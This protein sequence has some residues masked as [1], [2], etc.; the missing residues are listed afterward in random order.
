M[1]ELQNIYYILILF[2]FQQ[3]IY[4]QKEVVGKVEIY[5]SVENEWKILE[6][7][8]DGTIENLTNKEHQIKVQDEYNTTDFKTDSSGLFK[9]RTT[10]NDSIR[11]TVNDHSPI[12]NGEFHFDLNEI[13]D[14]LKLRI[15]D[16]KLAVYRDSILEPNFFS[17]FNEQQ[18]ETNFNN[19]K[20]ELLG[21]AVCWPS[22]ESAKRR[23][24]IEAEYGVKYRYYF[25]PTREKIRIMFRYN[26]VI[27]KLIGINKN[28]W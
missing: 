27:K 23:K 5:K 15:S 9:I 8:S 10:L 12:L 13:R 7:S 22:E 1:K 17:S 25:D 18:A 2:Y 24:Q 21:I 16:K 20:R 4:S 6:S 14:T 19:G 26:Q 11:I 3:N 28:V